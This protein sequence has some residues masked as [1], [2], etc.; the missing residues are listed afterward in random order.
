MSIQELCM[1]GYGRDILW[2]DSGRRLGR[3]PRLLA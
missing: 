1:A 3:V 2:I